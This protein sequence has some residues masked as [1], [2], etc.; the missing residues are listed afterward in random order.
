MSDGFPMSICTGSI[1]KLLESSLASDDEDE[2]GVECTVLLP[3][4]SVE[5]TET[6][7]WRGVR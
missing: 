3:L 7:L 6:W 1:S 5:E 4:S 2:D